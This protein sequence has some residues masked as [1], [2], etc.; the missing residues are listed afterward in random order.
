LVSEDGEG[1]LSIIWPTT[2][3]VGSIEISMEETGIDIESKG[4]ALKNWLLECSWAEEKEI[5]L[6][7][8]S[9]NVLMYNYKGNDYSVVLENGIISKSSVSGLQIK[10]RRGRVVVGLGR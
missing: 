6:E 2:D 1:E 3:P 7:E 9:A 10:P 4:K 8:Q 5:P